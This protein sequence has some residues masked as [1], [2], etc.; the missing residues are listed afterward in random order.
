MGS[1]LKIKVQDKIR[2]IFCENFNC[3]G[4]GNIETAYGWQHASDMGWTFEKAYLSPSYVDG[5]KYPSWGK[6]SPYNKDL[7][8]DDGNYV[9]AY[10]PLCSN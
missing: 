8:T 6:A 7:K 9:E 4:S 5:T 1:V 2:V 10:C 3:L